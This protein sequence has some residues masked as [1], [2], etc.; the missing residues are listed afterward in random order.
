MG[1]QLQLQ[2]PRRWSTEDVDQRRALSYWVD[3][4]CDRFLALEIES[5]LR[6]H[7]RARLEQTELGPATVNTLY[8][9]TQRVRRTH[10]NLAR[11]NHPVFVLL[12]LRVGQ[13]RLKQMGRENIVR[14]GESIFIDGTEPYE[15]EC[16]QPTNSLAL[17]MPEP[18]LKHWVPH[19]ERFAARLF[20]GG[21]W[22]A[23]LNA[24]LA[25]V[26]PYSCDDFALPRD[27]VAG[28]IA[29]LLAMAIGRDPEAKCGATLFD[30]LVHTLRNRL[31]EPGLSPVTVANQHRISKRSLHYAF[32]AADTTFVDELMRLRLVRA[33]EMLGDTR[34]ADLSV[35]DVAARCGFMDPSHFA[36]RFRQKFAQTP[37]Q[38]RSLAVR[39]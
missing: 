8:A 6:D 23:A 12:H 21:G 20:T 14:A 16:P 24:A 39:T 10:A 37:G 13:I 30:S 17:R 33:Q 15:L 11:S 9:E 38:F 26:N 34:F 28:Q 19:P 35:A 22:N 36:R 3:T 4:V 31:H 29:A 25:T 2:N 7:F 5:P 1:A 18:W 27:A 32:A